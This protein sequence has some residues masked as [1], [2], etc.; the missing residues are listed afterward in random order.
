M[1][2]AFLSPKGNSGGAAVA[3]LPM[4]GGGKDVEAPLSPLRGTGV[5]R[6]FPIERGGTGGRDDPLL[7]L[8]AEPDAPRALPLAPVGPEERVTW[9]G[10]CGGRTGRT[11]ASVVGTE[12]LDL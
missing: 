9:C 12:I 7:V 10:I 6:T 3:P 8:G 2:A 11:L 5:G 4:G 1:A